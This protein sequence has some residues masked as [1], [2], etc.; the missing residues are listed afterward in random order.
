MNSVISLTGTAENTIG[1]IGNNCILNWFQIAQWCFLVG[2][3]RPP[4]IFF[5]GFGILNRGYAE[6]TKRNYKHLPF[7]WKCS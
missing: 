5:F 1:P 3:I 2:P 6:G 7:R 4:M